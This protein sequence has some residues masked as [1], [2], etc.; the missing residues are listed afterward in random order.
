MKKVRVEMIIEVDEDVSIDEVIDSIHIP[1]RNKIQDVVD[2][3]GE[4][5]DEQTEGWSICYW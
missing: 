3:S 2:V 4:V 5:I 1:V